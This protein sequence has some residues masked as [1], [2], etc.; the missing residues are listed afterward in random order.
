MWNSY[1]VFC[2]CL[3]T[4]L[5]ASVLAQSFNNWQTIEFTKDA[6]P[7]LSYPAVSFL[8]VTVP[9][10]VAEGE[11]YRQLLVVRRGMPESGRNTFFFDPI[12]QS[13]L[14]LKVEGKHPPIVPYQSATAFPSQPGSPIVF[15]G[16]VRTE[17]TTWRLETS[18]VSG[19]MVYRW[20]RGA[21]SPY[22]NRRGHAAVALDTK[23]VIFGGME[24]NCGEKVDFDRIA[25]IISYDVRKDEWS[26]IPQLNAGPLIRWF[27]SHAS[28]SARYLLVAGG[29]LGQDDY[30]RNGFVFDL[31]AK[32]WHDLP[33]IPFGAQVIILASSSGIF[34]H[35]GMFDWV[36]VTMRNPVLNMKSVTNRRV[37]IP[38]VIVYRFS[39]ESITKGIWL[40]LNTSTMVLPGFPLREGAFPVVELSNV[41]AAV[42]YGR[43]YLSQSARNN[44]WFFLSGSSYNWDI[45]PSKSEP[46]P[47]ASMT[48]TLTREKHMYVCGG[49][50]LSSSPGQGGTMYEAAWRL[51]VDFSIKPGIYQWER[52]L[53]ANLGMSRITDKDVSAM[54]D[55]VDTNGPLNLRGHSSVAVDYPQSS[56]S[57]CL[58]LFGGIFRYI[59]DDKLVLVCPESFLFR[60]FRAPKTGHKWLR[61][62]S[63]RAFHTAVMYN[64]TMILYG[65]VRFERFPRFLGN[66][67][68]LASDHIWILAWNQTP[69]DTSA[70][71]KWLRQMIENEPLPRFGH[72]AVVTGSKML[73]FAGTDFQSI[74]SDLWEYDILSRR[75]R[76]ITYT[77]DSMSAN[78]LGLRHH[79]AVMG[80]RQM[81]VFGGCLKH[82]EKLLKGKD[83]IELC[84]TTQ[85]SNL[86]LAYDTY[87]SHWK[88]IESVKAPGRYFH[89]MI[90]LEYEKILLIYGGIGF[91]GSV[92]NTVLTLR[93]GCNSGEKGDVLT[94][95]C[96][97]CDLGYYSDRGGPL[98]DKCNL[99][100][101]TSRVGSS[102][103]SNCT[104]CSEICAF[105][106][107]CT[108]TRPN[109]EYEC[110]CKFPF[111]GNTCKSFWPLLVLMA[112]LMVSGAVGI[113]I[114]KIC[115][116]VRKARRYALDLQDREEEIDN[117]L[118]GWRIEGDELS[119]IRKIGQGGFGEVWLAEYRE[120]Q[121]AVKILNENERLFVDNS[122][123]D[124]QRE[125]DFMR[126]L[127][128]PNIVL[129]LGAG[130]FEDDGNLFLVTEFV[131]RGSLHGVLM[132]TSIGIAYRQQIQFCLDSAL[133]MRFL[134]GLNP[135]RI[136]RD[137]KAANLLVSHNWVVKVSDFGTARR[138]LKSQQNEVTSPTEISHQCS[139]GDSDDET[140]PLLLARYKKMSC[141]LG[142]SLWKAPEL[143]MQEAYGASVDVFRFVS[144]N[145]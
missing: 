104:Q 126:Q 64:N 78:S 136:H 48:L 17:N 55:S 3:V 125:I 116:Y 110:K 69:L 70:N 32:L 62:P 38:S 14:T 101:S 41:K 42:Y 81:F 123:E 45:I 105:G 119:F 67:A 73:I 93:P 47:L 121:V 54:I 131:I 31:K 5:L 98:C 72:T 92:K 7:A 85:I 20:K 33:E 46:G 28:V 117:L 96:Q 63:D 18:Q 37:A 8:N 71:I 25:K 1:K 106:G 142:T 84:R 57:S 74:F 2:F 9:R 86:L 11:R 100:F 114:Y 102:T 39:V 58:L 143:L 118:E 80:G 137:L 107:T 22:C 132:D 59:T 23:L 24:E 79:T 12:A 21:P 13:W 128:H 77:S 95:G 68:F 82:P 49:F 75:W 27:H 115:Q 122:N 108:A 65:G 127:R 15:V 91:D 40:K 111:S 76:K 135:P 66:Q 88:A 16:G 19:F 56:K 34:R 10:F 36:L 51:S 61:W 89:G 133:G 120:L 144:D 94:T 26:E 103:S 52:Y 30:P 29:M 6:S 130:S 50:S 134:H 35:E 97:P 145:F 141:R 113:L 124:F 140:Q 129:F 87:R 99:F 83:Q 53:P 138:L 44:K 109:V 60:T 139:N 90:F 112:S 4:A 43:M